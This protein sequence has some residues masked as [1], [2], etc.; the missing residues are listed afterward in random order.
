MERKQYSF[1]LADLKGRVVE[2]YAS[3]WEVDL[4]NDRVVKGAFR[5]TLAERGD[6]V[7]FL[8]NHNPGEPIG[9]VLELR[10]DAHGL[11][12]RAALSDT[13]RGNDLKALLSDGAIDGLSIGFDTVKARGGDPRE[14]LEARLWE[15]SLC[16]FQANLGARVTALKG[17]AAGV[18]ARR[19]RLLAEIEHAQADTPEWY[20]ARKEP[21]D[22]AERARL[23]ADIDARLAEKPPA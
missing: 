2:G 5:K 20:K 18:D 13:Q 23:L 3:T 21:V 9:R 10:E 12:M 22:E 6:R 11:F 8:W 17:K 16:T 15:I 19:R 7:R 1:E 14:I 4:E